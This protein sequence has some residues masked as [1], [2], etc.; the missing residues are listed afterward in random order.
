MKSIAFAAATLLLL[1]SNESHA[2]KRGG[3]PAG[4]ITCQQWCAKHFNRPNCMTGHFNSCDKKPGGA[5]A[6]VSPD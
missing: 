5:N 3:C 1:V 6:C 4:K 2:A